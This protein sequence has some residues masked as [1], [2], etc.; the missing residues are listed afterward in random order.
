MSSDLLAGPCPPGHS[1]CRRNLRP[2]N[3]SPP[4][5]PS[6]TP[7]ATA[8]RDSAGDDFSGSTDFRPVP[9]DGRCGGVPR[10]ALATEQH[11][12]EDP[13]QEGDAPE[14]DRQN[15]ADT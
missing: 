6:L 4:G 8:Q 12:A 14:D 2:D 13:D 15:A 11:G 3:G 1:P 9:G 7:A 5:L 10:L